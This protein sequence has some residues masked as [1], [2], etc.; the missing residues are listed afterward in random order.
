MPGV[1]GCQLSSVP[2]RSTRWPRASGCW[3]RV[4]TSE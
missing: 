3:R 4:P 2:H 1:R